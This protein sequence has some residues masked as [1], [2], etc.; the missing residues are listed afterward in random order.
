MNKFIG[1]GRLTQDVELR[2]LGDGKPVAKMTIA[3]DRDFKDKNGNKVTD[4]LNCQIWGKLAE[5]C[6]NN[7]S[8]GRLVAVEGSVYIDTYEK[9]GEKRKTTRINCQSVKF[10]DWPKEQR[11]PEEPAGINVD[12]IP[13]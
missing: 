10:L 7:L 3:I 8:K 4:F 9:D 13:F 6:A 1:I 11:G 5:I 2:Y 12:D